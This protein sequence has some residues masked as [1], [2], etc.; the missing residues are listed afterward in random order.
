MCIRDRLKIIQNEK[1]DVV[2]MDIQMPEMNGVEAT[3]IIR[4]R[5]KTTGGHLPIVALTAYAL[6]GDREKFLSV[7][8]DG[9][10]SKP[11]QINTIIDVLGALDGKLTDSKTATG[12][13]LHEDDNSANEIEADEFLTQYVK[14]V[15]TLLCDM[16]E[17]ISLLK[18]SFE[19]NDLSC[20]EKY[21]HEIRKS[22]AIMSADALKKSVFK[23]E[24]EARRGSMAQAAECFDSVM[25]EFLKYKKQIKDNENSRRKG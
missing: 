1:I 14:S 4:G 25:A 13:L 5:E 2:L 8:M 6:K 19:H 17:N 18:D 24:L 22:S 12:S 9:Y 23:L 11:V 20:I 10:I 16:D 7:G 21:A 15:R 3:R